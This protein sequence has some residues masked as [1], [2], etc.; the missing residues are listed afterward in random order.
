M[1]EIRVE[2]IRKHEYRVVLEQGSS[3]TSHR[4][5][6]SPQDLEHL[7]AGGSP[8][9]LVEES[10]RFLL[11]REPKESILRSFELAVIARYFPEYPQEIRRRLGGRGVR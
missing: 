4:V 1:V 8:E 7:V 11:E 10:F 2:S 3:R 5:T 9:A 6:V